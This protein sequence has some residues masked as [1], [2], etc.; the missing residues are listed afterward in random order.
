M[1]ATPDTA[2]DLKPLR[3]GH[4][5]DPDDAYMFYGLATGQA[6]IPGHKIQHV[7][8]DIETLNQMAM[9]S[10]IDV[11]AISTAVYP[12]LNGNF[13]ILPT[14]ASVGRNYGP[15]V[16]RR[17]DD[18]TPKSKKIAIPGKNTTAFLLLRLYAPGYQPVEYRFDEIPRALHR[19]DVDFGLLI[20]EAQ[21]TYE[22]LGF[23]KVINLGEAWMADT[24]LP[25]PLGLDVVRKG[26]GKDLAL[27]IWKGLKTSI[28]IANAQKDKAVD[29][30]LQYGRGLQ[31]D[32][33]EKFVGMYVNDDTLELGE[34]GE[35]ALSRLFDKAYRAGI[36]PKPTP[37]EVLRA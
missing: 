12:H 5:P 17:G 37:I 11:T 26:L 8:E 1:S 30:A 22:T 18:P 21:L 9:A 23:T 15:V 2:A 27:D 13:W 36:Y 10:E 16:V 14:G 7:L 28:E 4:T 20:H 25:I 19:G 34:E 32:L 24:G 31:K 3:F 33:G 29:Y 35:A 6:S